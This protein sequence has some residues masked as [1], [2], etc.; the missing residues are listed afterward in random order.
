MVLLQISVQSANTSAHV[1]AEKQ[2]TFVRVEEVHRIETDYRQGVR[3][4]FDR[5]ISSSLEDLIGM[6]RNKGL[7]YTARTKVQNMRISISQSITDRLS[8]PSAGQ[9]RSELSCV[10]GVPRKFERDI[11]RTCG[12]TETT[13]ELRFEHHTFSTHS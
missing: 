5:I 2:Q 4:D 12:G 10:A 6:K 1:T 7:P 13:A 11:V 3:Y 9:V 8:L